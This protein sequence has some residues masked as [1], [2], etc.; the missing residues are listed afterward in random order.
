MR[1]ILFFPFALSFLARQ[2]YA[3][4]DACLYTADDASDCKD[5]GQ[6]GGETVAWPRASQECL[7]VYQIKVAQQN[8]ASICTY[9]SAFVNAF[10]VGDLQASDA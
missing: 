10:R 2:A 9:A 8:V 5:Y 3:Q 4:C 1:F 6:L 7:D